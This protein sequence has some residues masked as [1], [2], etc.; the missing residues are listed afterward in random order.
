MQQPPPG[1]GG[2]GQHPGAFSFEAKLEDEERLLDAMLATMARGSLPEGTWEQLHAAAQRDERLSELAFGFESA[3]QGKRLKLVPPAVAADFLFQAARFFGDVFG[4]E[5]GAVTYLERALVLVP[6]HV[7]AFAKIEQLLEKTGNVRKLADV[8]AAT[9][10]HRPRGEQ[11]PIL[12]RAAQLLATAGG[13]DDKV[14]DL[15]QLVLRL[16]PGDEDSRARLE[17]LYVKNNRLRDVVRLNEQALASEPPPEEWVRK[18]LLLRIIELYEARLHEPERAMPHIEQMLALDPASEEARRVAQKLLVIKGLA[19]RAASALAQAAEA[20]GTPPEIVRYLSIELES[21]RGPKRAALLTRLGKLKS[22]RMGDDKGALEAFE[23]ALAID[24]TDDELRARYVALA[25]KLSRFVDAAKTLTRVLATMK[26]PVAKAK[27]S[28]QLGEMLLRANEARRAKATLAGVLAMPEAPPEATL[29]AAYLLREIH[30]AEADARALCD[31]LERIAALE[32]DPEKRRE[33][34]DQVADLATML[35]DTPRAIAAF[36]RLLPTASRARALAAL[37]P[38]YEAGGDPLKHALLLEEQAKD[39]TDEV[40]AREQMMRAAEVRASST[41]DAAAAVATCLAVV[42]RF[43]PARDVLALLLPLLEAQKQWPELARALEQE[44]SLLAGPEHARAM[45]RL[46]V[47]RMQRLRDLDGAI[48]AFD[49]ALA[50]DATDKT[51][52]STLEKLTAA[53]DHRLQAARVLEPVYRR[54]SATGPLLKLLELRGALASTVEDRL[55]ALREAADLAAGGGATEAARALDV[56]GRGLAEAVAGEQPL[57]EWLDRVDRAAGTGTDPKKRAA[58]LAK[59][60]G[61]R[62]VTSDE[63]SLLAKKAAEASA[64]GGDVTAAIALYRKALAFEPHS[65]ELL[66]RIDDLLRDQGSPRERI[67]LYRAAI[68]RAGADRRRELLH[69]IGVIERHDLE[70]LPAAIATYRTAL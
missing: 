65:A 49:E 59:A 43:G 68:P 50:F 11:A 42:E 21:T 7:K 5:L 30:A 14:I 52:R 8:Y 58:V 3:S 29:A 63:L 70:D 22:E 2:S 47:L 28:A 45:S 1:R 51:A 56:A 16:E 61:D 27:A 24:G 17:A 55:A 34:D 19:G 44:A 32:P 37:A 67:A 41:R 25:T 46:G 53:G 39:E 13:A 12:R 69:R 15:L 60:I 31:V 35:K 23:Q 38:L 26:D 20:Y 57:R 18:K 10:Q 4:D 6:G 54:E 48:E 64:A 36:E 62:E 9:A 66:S 40:K 33:A